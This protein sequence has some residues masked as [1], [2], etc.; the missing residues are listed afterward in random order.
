[1]FESWR[2]R[3]SD[4]PRA[5]SE[6]LSRTHPEMT[7]WWTT[8]DRTPPRDGTRA[9]VR[10][11]VGYFRRLLTSSFLVTNDIVTK[12]L[13]KGPGVTYLQCC[14]GT[15]LKVIAH[16]EVDSKYSGASAH[17]KRVDRDVAKWDY[18][19][20]PSPACTE[21]MRRAYQYDG[22]IL[23]TGYPRN[24][25]VI[26]DDGTIRERVRRA[27]G[28]APDTTAI[29]YA[30][31][32][33]DDTKDSSGNFIQTLYPDFAR[34]ARALPDSVVLTRLHPHVRG[35]IADV[36]GFTI[37]V[38][39][40]DELMELFLAA[41][42][43]VSDYSSAIF[44]FPITGKPIVLYAPDLEHYRNDL[45]PL[46]F[47]YETWAPGPIVATTDELADHLADLD[48]VSVSYRARYD[49]FVRTFC[50]YD[51]GN[52]TQRVIEAVFGAS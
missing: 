15:P 49:E 10:H 20:S 24:D 36:P 32:W 27:L 48:A 8:K 26:R 30:P 42:A 44:D 29:L 14:R 31:T 19:L 46:Y 33:R 13:V 11:S 40:H 51:D 3:Y 35:S 41:D 9:V 16:D 4:S 47:E 43:F 25:M 21:I 12:H 39:D 7:Q 34:L 2:G 22:V 23:E 45:R 38:S 5:I 18:L 28:I 1:M 6:A 50:P 52:A 17:L 37:D